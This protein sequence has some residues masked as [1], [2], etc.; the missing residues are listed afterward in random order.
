MKPRTWLCSLMALLLFAK[1][2]EA[3]TWNVRPVFG[4]FPADSGFAAGVELSKI[5]L[6]GPMDGRIR[7]L[8]SV[9]KYEL[10]QVEFG[11]PDLRPSLS[12]KFGSRY[13]NYPQDDF[14]GV[15]PNSPEERRANYLLEDVDTT[16]TLE[17]FAGGFRG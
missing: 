14:W 15:G 10:L 7:A 1:I 6:A 17:T 2:G 13:R 4:G 9:K 5:R 16:A 12:V 3:Q 11:I 8:A